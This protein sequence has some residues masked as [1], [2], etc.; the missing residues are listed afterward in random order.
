MSDMEGSPEPRFSH[1][2]SGHP[3]SVALLVCKADG[4]KGS[5]YVMR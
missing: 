2:S 3:P 5:L 4:Q 1:V